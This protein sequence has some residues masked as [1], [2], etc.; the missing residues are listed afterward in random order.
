[1][2]KKISIDRLR[3]GMYVHELCA[4]W[5]SHPFWRNQF[6]VKTRED[7][8][9]VREA[10]IR[11][12]Y[13]DTGR[14]LDDA[15]A[16]TAEEVRVEVEHE[17]LAAVT[18]EPVPLQKASLEEELGRAR[19]VHAQAHKVVRGMMQDV[20]L[21]RAITLDNVEPVIEAVTG[22][23]LRNGSALLGL[24]GIKNKDDYTFLHS[25]SVCTLMIAFGRTL[26]LEGEALR[27]AGIGGLLH[28]VGK[29]KVPDA[30]LNKPGRLT[31]AEFELIKRHPADGHAILLES[32]G[33]GAVPLDITLHHHERIDGSGYPDKLLGDEISTMA[34]MA[35]IVD[36]Y[37]A[38][39]ADRCYH[40][41][42]APTEA[43]RKMW[44]WSS[45]HFD[46][47]LLQAFMRCI[48]IYPIGSLVLLESG[49]LGVVIEQNEKSV[50]TPVVR[51]FFNTRSNG[52][53]DPENIDL[54]RP[55]GAGDRIMSGESPEKWRVDPLKF[56]PVAA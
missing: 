9:R 10:G 27:Q 25:V 16:R 56:M 34:R 44:E 5:M 45:A 40:K 50:L 4:D 46:Q 55:P 39:T 7:V 54:A 13:I 12:L 15:V 48:G 43:L 37:D 6:L 20:R 17:M 47:R 21:G 14:G 24:I 29:M 42:M 51:V 53:I 28:D 8:Q 35:A 23:I 22:S 31:E 1:M 52:Y 19:S 18:A 38:I 32:S 11:E 33:V 41:G 30:V 2:L 26:G 36:V 3:P 49:R